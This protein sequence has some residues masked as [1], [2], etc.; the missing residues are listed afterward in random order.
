MQE[1]LAWLKRLLCLETFVLRFFIFELLNA[2][3][4]LLQDLIGLLRGIG[5]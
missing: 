2:A 4:H 1:A 5:K 3:F